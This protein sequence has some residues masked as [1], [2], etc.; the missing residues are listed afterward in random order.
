[1]R[2]GVPLAKFDDCGKLAAKDFADSAKVG[3]LLPSVAHGMAVPAAAEG[4][5]KD[6]VSQ[7]WNVDKMTA[8]EG[9]SKLVA[10]ARTR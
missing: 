2:A 4:A 9:M 6:V 5:M 1:V 10:A 3:S 7:F 8:K